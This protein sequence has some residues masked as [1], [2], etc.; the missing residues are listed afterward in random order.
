MNCDC[1]RCDG[2]GFIEID[3]DHC[4]G[5]GRVD[6]CVSE[7]KLAADSD[8]ELLRLQD[9]ANRVIRDTE[10]LIALRPE[11]ADSYLRQRDATLSVINREATKILE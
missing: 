10:R 8:P 7:A 5:T 3:C 11:A 9:D 1:K 6:V 4:G 2:E